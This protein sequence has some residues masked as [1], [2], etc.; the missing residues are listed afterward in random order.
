[1]PLPHPN[2]IPPADR[3]NDTYTKDTHP[4]D[5]NSSNANHRALLRSLGQNP[6]GTYG[7]VQGRLQAMQDD[8]DRIENTANS[9][10]QLAADAHSRIDPLIG[11][12][13][14]DGGS[15]APGDGGGQT[16]EIQDIEANDMTSGTLRFGTGFSVGRQVFE[17]G[18]D[19]TTVHASGGGGSAF[20]EDHLAYRVADRVGLLQQMWHRPPGRRVGVK[21]A[22]LMGGQFGL[23][24]SILTVNPPV[25]ADNIGPNDEFA[26]RVRIPLI[27]A[28]TGYIT[29]VAATAAIGGPTVGGD[30]QPAAAATISVVRVSNGQTILKSKLHRPTP[31]HGFPFGVAGYRVNAAD[32]YTEVWN[33]QTQV[34]RGEV[35]YIYIE[36]DYPTDG[37][38]SGASAPYNWYPD[39]LTDGPFGW[40]TSNQA[41]TSHVDDPND[42]LDAEGNPISRSPDYW[43]PSD[44]SGH[45]TQS[46]NDLTWNNPLTHVTFEAGVAIYGVS[47][48][49]A[50]NKQASVGYHN[51]ATGTANSITPAIDG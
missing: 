2:D 4:I 49:W 25:G 19:L 16:L 13:H 35:L 23:K 28:N 39:A 30:L 26:R 11:H 8:D 42:D 1:M 48:A 50:F 47:D 44:T 6:E 7:T 21:E 18:S 9:A 24:R 37:Q 22:A 41:E 29:S 27:A 34:L 40:Y 10:L 14:G 15:Y 17:D 5:H 46:A 32:G 20:E 45:G 31:G 3:G 12:S 36:A 51:P 38:P 43:Y 33:S